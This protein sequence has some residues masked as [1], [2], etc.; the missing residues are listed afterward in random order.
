MFSNILVISLSTL[1][2]FAE[3]ICPTSCICKEKPNISVICDSA[4]LKNIPMLLNPRMTSL[5]VRNSFITT[6]KA[7]DLSFY[8][9]LQYL[10]LSSNQIS[11]IESSSFALLT[12]LNFL[13]LSSNNLAK[14]H[15]ATFKGSA[16]LE[17]LDLSNNHLTDISD[18]LF[19]EL[20]YFRILKL[21]K[22]SLTEIPVELEYLQD[23]LDLSFNQ[24][25]S[26]SELLEFQ[27][28]FVKKLDLSYN[29]LRKL[30]SFTFS[31]FVELEILNLH[32][33]LITD[34]EDYAFAGLHQL[35]SLDI[36]YNHIVTLP[37]TT[38]FD[39]LKSL[40]ISANNFISLPTGF[41][42]TLAQ[43]ERLTVE[44][45]NSIAK[46]SADSFATLKN[47]HLLTIANNSRLSELDS[48]AFSNLTN[49]IQLNLS[50][51]NL[52]NLPEYLLADS[53]K[54]YDVQLSGNPWHCNCNLSFSMLNFGELQCSTPARLKG[55]P[56]ST[57][58]DSELDCYGRT[59]YKGI[60]AGI[61][62][63]VIAIVAILTLILLLLWKHRRKFLSVSNDNC[64]LWSTKR[65]LSL[66]KSSPMLRHHSSFR[67]LAE[68]PVPITE[69]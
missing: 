26:D 10:D 17:I 4:K 45:C 47:L 5:T 50:G 63:V 22:N 34:V 7:D 48:R 43:L 52:S 65:V 1:I 54:L 39:S 19:A 15:S 61:L 11:L 3:S 53:V 21:N 35:K 28:S 14:I 32:H 23:E 66:K 55:R 16:M 29:R 62:S 69:L 18:S 13:N 30:S 38:N 51:N 59:I 46:I 27:G 42:R 20:K 33:N 12:K 8:S 9:E 68:Y 60:M 24:I 37:S 57:L 31:N 2:Q 49:L 44:S 25:S 41:F 36:S 58:S 40:V 67:I 56:L 64:F 6:V